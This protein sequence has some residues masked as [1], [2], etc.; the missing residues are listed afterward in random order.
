MHI[1]FDLYEFTMEDDFE[2]YYSLIGNSDVPYPVLL[3]SKYVYFMLDYIYLPRDVFKAKMSQKEW[4][5]A[6]QYFYGYKDYDTGKESECHKKKPA[7]EVDKCKKARKDHV[8][9][10]NKTYG[11][12]FKDLD[13]VNV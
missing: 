13:I 7:K 4:E 9:K 1:G 12:K 3:G 10:I 2:A 8:N 11:K 5:D 6:Y